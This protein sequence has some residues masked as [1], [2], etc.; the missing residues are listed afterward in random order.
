MKKYGFEFQKANGANSTAID[1][2][3]YPILGGF[4]GVVWT[5]LV[6]PPGSG[7]YL[8]CLVHIVLGFI[9][10]VF[11]RFAF[12]LIVLVSVFTIVIALYLYIPDIGNCYEDCRNTYWHRLRG[13]EPKILSV[14]QLSLYML[15]LV[16]YHFFVRISR[17]SFAK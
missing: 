9:A 8:L 11:P 6:F 14:L 12:T 15:V 7:F 13:Y 10:E 5:C 2:R 16:V 1:L 4:L 3:Y 17:Y